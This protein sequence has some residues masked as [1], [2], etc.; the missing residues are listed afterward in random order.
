MASRRAI[1]LLLLMF[2]L[3]GL[4]AAAQLQSSR[5]RLEFEHVFGEV[6]LRFEDVSLRTSGGNTISVTRLSYLVSNVRLIRSD[7]AAQPADAIGFI[8]AV[9]ARTGFD[10]G[11]TPAGTYSAI[12]FD[13]GL[14][15]KVNHS[16]PASYGPDHPLNPVLNGLHWSWQGGYVFLAIEGRYVLP[17]DQ[18]GG[19]SYHI[20]TDRHV[21]HVKVPGSMV[22]GQVDVDSELTVRFDVARL[23]DRPNRIIIHHAGG[24]DSTHSGEDDPLAGLLAMNI[25]GSFSFAGLSQGQSRNNQLEEQSAPIPAGT[26]RYFFAVPQGFGEPALPRDNPLTLEGVALGKK[27]FF[28][29][30]LSA[31]NAQSCADC[32]HPE[33]A[34]SD[35]GHAFSKGAEGLLGKRNTMPLFNLAWMNSMTWDGKRSRVRDQAL[36]PIQDE[37]EMHQ[38]LEASVAK[39]GADEAYPGLFA[40]AFGSPGITP[41][42]LGLA[43]EQ[44]LLTLTSGDSKFDRAMREE[45]QLTD[46]EK[47][48]LTLFVLEFD[49]ARGRLGADCFHCHGNELFTNNQF[50]NNG[51]DS[52][53]TDLGRQA[54]TGRVADAGKFKVPSLRNVELTGPYMHDGRFS[55]LEE[56]IDHYADGVKPSDSLDPNISKH[57]EGGLALNCD[58]RKALVAFLKTL[59]DPKYR[60]EPVPPGPQE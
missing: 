54:A 51:L 14:E 50:K 18:L 58:D 8:D 60:G 15:P 24:A 6:P 31:N 1:L 56:V 4:Q 43:L 39:L 9:E 27:L 32:H 55:T 21:M 38:S 35:A 46:E 53:F 23:F 41:E 22:V 3:T 13:I 49:P 20:A 2:W 29:K 47:H 36:A 42:R 45:V 37:R 16:D 44:Y 25:A 59:T 34:F 10:L 19:Y 57:P 52:E 28:D 17:A 30:S 26:R 33:A 12:E 40:Q 11:P 5:V 7:G 48:G